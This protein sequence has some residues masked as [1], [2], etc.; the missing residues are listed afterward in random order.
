MLLIPE[1]LRA[2]GREFPSVRRRV[3]EERYAAQLHRAAYY[4]NQ[5][6]LRR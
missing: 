5:E 3:S 6:A 2:I 4:V 1:T